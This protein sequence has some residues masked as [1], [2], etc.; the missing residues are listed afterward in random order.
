[1]SRQQTLFP[2]HMT[3][4][5][6]ALARAEQLAIAEAQQ[7]PIQRQQVAEAARAA[8]TATGLRGCWRLLRL[9]MATPP[10]EIRIWSRGFSGW[11]VAA[12]WPTAC[13]TATVADN[14]SQ[15]GVRC[16]DLDAQ[17]TLPLEEVERRLVDAIKGQLTWGTW[18]WQE[19]QTLFLT[20]A[21]FLPTKEPTS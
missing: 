19:N 17:P 5:G 3:A 14:P 15:E 21:K 1:M 4:S 8:D 7:R 16:E 12:F 2:F 11:T 6:M 13:F 10:Q 9:P 20:W 18:R